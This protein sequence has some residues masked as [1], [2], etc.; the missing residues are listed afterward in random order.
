MPDFLLIFVTDYRKN[1]NFLYSGILQIWKYF[2]GICKMKILPVNYSQQ[3]KRND[4]PAR[5]NNFE[6]QNDIFIKSQRLQSPNFKGNIYQEIINNPDLAKKFVGM[7]AIG[8]GTLFTAANA[9]SKDNK[10]TSADSQIDGNDIFSLIMK[11]LQQQVEQ[12]E[13]NATDSKNTNELEYLRTR[14]TQLEKENSRLL[15]QLKAY[16]TDESPTEVNPISDNEIRIIGEDDENTTNKVSAEEPDPDSIKQES[17]P[18]EFPKKHGRL[19]TS[20]YQLK[21]VVSEL[22]LPKEENE[23]LTEICKILLTNKEFTTKSGQKISCDSLTT[24]LANRITTNKEQANEIINICYKNLELGNQ[25]EEITTQETPGNDPKEPDKPIEGVENADLLRHADTSYLEIKGRSTGPKVLGTIDLSTV[26]RY[27]KPK[28][29]AAASDGVQD[30]GNNTE[31]SAADETSGKEAGEKV[32][33][34]PVSQATPIERNGVMSSSDIKDPAEDFYT[35]LDTTPDDPRISFPHFASGRMINDLFAAPESYVFE[36]Q[37][38]RGGSTLRFKKESAGEI[39]KILLDFEQYFSNAKSN[40]QRRENIKIWANN[41]LFPPEK[42]DGKTDSNT[43]KNVT[44][45]TNTDK[46]IAENVRKEDIIQEVVSKGNNDYKNIKYSIYGKPNS[47]WKQMNFRA[48][49]EILDE[50]VDAINGDERFKNFGFHGA[51]RLIERLVDFSSDISVQKQ[52]T[53]ILDRLYDLIEKAVQNGIQVK[54]YMYIY[55]KPDKFGNII[56][57]INPNIVI[58]KELYTPEDR[59]LFN[60][61]D[62]L[63]AISEYQPKDDYDKSLKQPLIKTI[64]ID[65][66]W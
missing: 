39:A 9:G 3:I 22:L 8:I 16:N 37:F 10:N 34:S 23:K 48:N 50:I 5:T 24:T 49:F 7:L 52:C 12:P 54:T 59:K 32:Y 26:G 21:N 42:S 20:Q 35:R 41:I 2:K 60:D 57:G 58:P 18:V 29:P 46:Y 31:S 30:G 19:S 33:T 1:G 25:E 11:S 15:E 14:N 53:Y 40:E 43:L 64:V 36:S 13:A 44:L 55:D 27:G 63:I 17:Y 28:Q 6:H 56:V 62:I 38:G 61:D 4:L 45:R 65:N 47:D 66:T 51:L